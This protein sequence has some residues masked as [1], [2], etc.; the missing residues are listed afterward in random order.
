MAGARRTTTLVEGSNVGPDD[1]VIG[2]S[3][4]KLGSGGEDGDRPARQDKR[5]VPSAKR[6][7]IILCATHAGL[8]GLMP[9]HNFYLGWANSPVE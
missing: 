7:Q 4:E 1:P 6:D 8:V 2:R 5:W 9:R 3:P